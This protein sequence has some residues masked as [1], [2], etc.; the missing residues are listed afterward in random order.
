MGFGKK[1]D[2]Q[3]GRVLDLDRSYQYIIK[4]AAVQAGL[5][6]MRADEIVHSGLIDVPMYEQLLSAD[7]VIG[8][9]R[10]SPNHY[11]S[12]V[13]RVLNPSVSGRFAITR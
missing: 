8:A 6:C 13:P 12:C 9:E 10:K 2:Y 11:R 4:P 7:V 1:T 5:D 3:S